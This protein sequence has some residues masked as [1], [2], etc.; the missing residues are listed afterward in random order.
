M[1]SQHKHSPYKTCFFSEGE[2]PDRREPP[3]KSNV[4][5]P[6]FKVVKMC[7]FRIGKRLYEKLNKHSMFSR[8]E[9]R[10]KN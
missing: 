9:Y 1:L 5:N 8:E 7:F 10:S 2:P 4:T 3:H 6:S